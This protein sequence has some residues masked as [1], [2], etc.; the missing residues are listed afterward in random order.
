MISKVKKI[1]LNN[2]LCVLS[3]CSKNVPD[4]SLMLYICD[5]SCTKMYMLT[6]KDSTKYFNIVGNKNVSILVDTRDSEK[7][8]T[9]QTK[10]LTINGQAS[11]IE[12]GEI[13][14]K[15]IKQLINKHDRL[16]N[17]ASNKNVRVIEVLIKDILFLEDV[18]TANHIK[19]Y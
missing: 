2:S 18:D 6:L 14:D 17:L 13:T 15:L 8:E 11:I 3:T 9:S 4:A 16:V 1:L 10:A 5:E 19:L 12:A 7:D